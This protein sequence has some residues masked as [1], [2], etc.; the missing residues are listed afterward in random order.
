MKTRIVLPAV[1][2]CL[3]MLTSCGAVRP[4]KYYE[5]TTAGNGAVATNS[6]P[7]PVTLLVGRITTSDLYRD[8][9]I[10]YTS[11]GQA[12]G[13]Y[14]FQK[15]AE[16]PFEMIGD[17]L[18][19][20]L[21]TSG[22]YRSVFSSRSDVRGDYLLRGHLYELREVDGNVLAARV[23]FEF[24]LR[25]TKTGNIIWNHYYSH[26]EPVDGKDVAAVVAAM[27]RNVHSGLSEVMEGLDQYF[28]TRTAVS[29]TAAR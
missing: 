18:L 1:S 8:N 11:S 6:A 5:F 16:P 13:A 3:G 24:E 26:D 9:Q 25:D 29:S 20:E 23:G 22:R 2:L 21:Q 10:I 17:V 4:S 14:E 12:M 19:R 7:Y 28:S 15:W 27:D